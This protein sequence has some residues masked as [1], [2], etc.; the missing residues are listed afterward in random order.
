MNEKNMN[1]TADD[2]NRMVSQVDLDRWADDGGPCP[3]ETD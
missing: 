3:P 1:A 2:Q